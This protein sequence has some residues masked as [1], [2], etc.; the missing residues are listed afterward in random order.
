[1]KA[2]MKKHVSAEST[3]ETRHQKSHETE[4]NDEA[5]LKELVQRPTL[6]EI[7]ATS[8]HVSLIRTFFTVLY[9]V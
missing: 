5:L 7:T 2:C 4:T 6:N 8:E 3:F 9:S 1:M